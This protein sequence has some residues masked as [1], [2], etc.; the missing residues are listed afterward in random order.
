MHCNLPCFV[1]CEHNIA[2]FIAFDP[3]SVESVFGGHLASPTVRVDAIRSWSMT[4][5]LKP[6]S[7]RKVHISTRITKLGLPRVCDLSW[8]VN[9]WPSWFSCWCRLSLVL[10]EWFHF[11]WLFNSWLNARERK[12]DC[13]SYSHSDK[14]EDSSQRSQEFQAE[15]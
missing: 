6:F 5:P 15:T 8:A 12:W 10:F 7:R 1:G 11:T 3:H 13:L 4:G 14:N 9:G 2:K